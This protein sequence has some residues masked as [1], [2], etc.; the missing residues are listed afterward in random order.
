MKILS[1]AA[2]LVLAASAAMA[3]PVEGVWKT[4]PGDDGNF[5]LVTISACG[6][7]ICGVLGQGYDKAGKKIDSPNIGKR[8]IWAM[9][10]NG[11]G[12]YSGGKIWA[13]DRD[14]TYNSKMTLSGN[15][16]KVEGCVLG[17]CRGQT[18]TRVK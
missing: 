2:G 7:E 10:P 5:G 6:A 16:L 1:I 11:G 3:D 17:I 12:Q 13:P 8:M 4:Q 18:W 9:K 15:Q 14:K